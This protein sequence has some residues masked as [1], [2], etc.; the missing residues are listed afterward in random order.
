MARPRKDPALKALRGTLRKDREPKKAPAAIAGPMVAPIPLSVRALEHFDAIAA[1]LRSEARASQHFAYTVAL[2][3]QRLDQP[4]DA[5]PVA[6]LLGLERLRHRFGFGGRCFPASGVEA[7]EGGLG[8][9]SIDGLA[10]QFLVE[11]T[12]QGGVVRASAV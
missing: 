1:M 8:H 10:T 6:R 2:L 12:A 11:P 7:R 5:D 9:G 4:V 3:A